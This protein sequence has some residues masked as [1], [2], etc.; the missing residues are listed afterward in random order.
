MA[1]D[2]WHTHVPL[3]GQVLTDKGLRAVGV[4]PS[5]AVPLLDGQEDN[6]G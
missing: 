4:E 5:V 1:E 3:G 6:D 2:R